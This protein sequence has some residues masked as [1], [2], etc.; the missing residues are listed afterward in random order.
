MDLYIIY[1]FIIPFFGIFFLTFVIFIIQFLW[2]KMNE[3]SDK[4]ISI[5]IIIKFIFCFGICTIPLITIISILLSTI[6]T[7]GELSENGELTVIKSSGISLFRIML[8]IFWIT[9]I[10][11]IGLYLFSDFIIP[12]AEI[13]I[14]ELGYKIIYTYPSLKLKEGVINNIGEN[15]FINIE[16][17]FKNNY[18]YKVIIF[19]YDDYSNINTIF[20]KKCNIIFNK[21]NKFI[22]LKLINGFIYKENNEKNKKYIPNY[23][24]VNFNTLIK[25][26]KFPYFSFEEIKNMNDDYKYKKTT[27]LIKKI[28]FLKKKKN[29]ININKINKIKLEIYKKLTFPITCI[30]MFFIGAPLGA[31]VKKGGIGYPTIIALTIYSLYYIILTITKNKVE[32][33]EIIPWIGIWIPN[34]V[35]LLFSIF[36][37]NKSIMND[38]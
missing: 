19:F 38:S 27:E 34:F 4:D 10:L 3:L 8:P 33:E 12:K 13:K 23:Y 35:L 22:Q 15:F 28:K 25:N 21:K 29:H 24:I 18:F 1:S 9:M 36:I 32:K 7:F 37:T 31:I 30:I 2:S 16:K 6:I 17:K 14:K 20:S 11:S 5:F 26:F